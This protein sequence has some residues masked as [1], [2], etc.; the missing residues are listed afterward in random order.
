MG[1]LLFF[2]RK[3]CKHKLFNFLNNILD[4]K[5]TKQTAYRHTVA[6]RAMRM[7]EIVAWVKDERTRD[8]LALFREKLRRAYPDKRYPFTRKLPQLLFA[9]TFR[10]GELKEYNGWILLEINRLK[11]IEEALSLKQKIVEYPQTLFAMIGSSGRSVKFVVAYTYPDGSLPRSRTD[12]EVFH[13]HAYRHALKTY[14]PRLSYP[15]E[16]K[17]P[18]LE[19]GCR[20][21]YDV[22]VYYNPD[23]LSIHL[24]QPVAMPD[25]SAYQER[26]EK[27]VPVP[28]ESAGQ[29]LY[30]QYRYVAIQYEFALQRALEEHGSLS[31]KVDFKPLL[32]TLGRLC[33]AAGV[34]EEDCVKWTMLYLG[35]LISEVEIRETLRQSYRLASDSDFGSTSLYKPEQLQSLKMEEF[36]NRRY[37]FRY[38][39][40]SG[41]PEYREKNTFCFDYRPVTDRVLNSIALNAQ[42]EGLQLWDRDVR[43]FV[44]SDRIPDYAP[45]EDYLTRLPVWDGKDRIRPLAARIPCDNVRWEQLFYTWFLS[46][47]A[48]WQGRDK[49][50]GNSLSPLLVGGQGCGK[51]T[52]CFNLLPPDLN[53][54]YTDSIDFSK[55]RDAELYLTRFGLINIDEFDQVSARHQG[56]LK[57]LLQKPVVNVRKPHA[58]QVESVK[59]YASFI[60]TSNHTDLLG[61]PSGSRRFI[62]IE[63]KG[64]IDNAQPIDYLQLY[65]QAVAALNNNERYWLTHEEEV[66]QMQANEAFQQRPL[67]EDLFFQYYR[68]ASHKEE[69]L[70]ISAGEIYLS[71]QKKSGVKLPMSNVSVFGRFLKKIGLKTQLASRG[72]LYLVVEK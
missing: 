4:M 22:D 12:A 14:E 31:I 26:F 25:E 5:I 10:K 30:D 8:K 64:L 36:M 34:E 71:L 24:E 17:R 70:K 46:M 35:N 9:G 66:S 50:H 18:V 61:D 58:T 11:S 33:F 60:A 39:L 27:R 45:I 3:N 56:F 48:H 43:R 41:G 55:K 52:F 16:L 38:N 67:F 47:V 32:V 69:G 57:H 40:M 49:Q 65:A 68:P 23:A 44:F 7:E 19:M 54:Y 28:V 13:A 1:K 20:L 6:Q 15:I 72:R 63:V 2:Y 62:C 42:K 37:D 59:R 21:S 51:S 29:T 53:K